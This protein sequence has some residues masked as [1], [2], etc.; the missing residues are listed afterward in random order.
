MTE[1]QI[2]YAGLSFGEGPRWHEDRL[3]VSDFHTHRVLAIDETGGAETIV[4][5]PNR[6]SGLGWLPD[7]RL[8]VVSMTDRKLMRLD[9]DGLTEH[10]DLGG[11]ATGDCNDMVVD[12]ERAR[13]R[14]E[15][16]VRLR[17]RREAAAQ[18]P[19]RWSHPMASCRQPPTISSSRTGP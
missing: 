6:P 13:L 9:P 17:R 18:R 5:V 2:L 8:L 14:G 10:A 16:R 12:P 11:I 4:E 19:S 1:P 15:L 3:W 7:G